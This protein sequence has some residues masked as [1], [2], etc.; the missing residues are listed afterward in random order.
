M[1]K[2]SKKGGWLL[3]GEGTLTTDSFNDRINNSIETS[4][5]HTMIDQKLNRNS[6]DLINPIV[7]VDEQPAALAGMVI[8]PNI[9]GAPSVVPA[10]VIF[11]SEGVYYQTKDMPGEGG[12]YNVFSRLTKPALIG[13]PRHCYGAFIPIESLDGK[14]N[15]NIHNLLEQ[16]KMEPILD[17]DNEF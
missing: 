13:G 16:T 15:V 1:N 6:R 2:L 11:G 3:F 5:N 7:Y 8:P 14:G 10:Q 12:M 4:E 17:P 9:K